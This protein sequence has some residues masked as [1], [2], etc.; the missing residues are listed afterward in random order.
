M[1]IFSKATC[2]KCNT[3]FY[4]AINFGHTAHFHLSFSFDLLQVK[5]DIRIKNW[6]TYYVIQ[7][8]KKPF[9]NQKTPIIKQ[10]KNSTKVILVNC[11]DYC[12]GHV[13]YKLL[14]SLEITKKYPEYGVIVIIPENFQWL[15][16]SQVS[17]AW[18]FPHN[19]NTF[20]NQ[21]QGFNEFIHKELNRFETV[22]IHPLCIHPNVQKFDIESFLKAKKFD[23]KNYNNAPLITF[24]YRENR[25]WLNN[26]LINYFY[27]GLKKIKLDN[28]LPPIFEYYQCHLFSKVAYQIKK[29]CPDAN[30]AITG[31]GLKGKAIKLITDKRSQIIT[32][33]IERNWCDLYSQ[34]LLVIGVHGSNMIIPTALAGGFIEVLPRHKIDHLTE[35]INQN[36]SNRIASFLGRYV[37]EFSSTKLVATHAISIINNFKF[38]LKTTEEEV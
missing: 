23:L 3:G 33:Q 20:Q 15:I 28:I 34:S 21:I 24:I 5:T 11:L 8:F 10:F 37:D 14:N 1:N 26:K 27:K 31:I 4:Q 13:F 38:Y 25:L 19:L 17:E 7:S 30:F 16:P 29:K 18:I 6:L 22:K 35:D 12:Y 36:Y 2:K 9:I 32:E